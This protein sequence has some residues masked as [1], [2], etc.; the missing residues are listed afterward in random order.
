MN[1]LNCSTETKNPKF[2]SSSCSASYN[3]HTKPKRTRSERFCKH[4]GESVGPQLSRG[5]RGFC[6]SDCK[7][8]QL[9][10][11]LTLGELKG[12][13]NA[14]RGGR[15]PMI[16]NWSRKTYIRSGRPMEC[17]HC[18]YDYHVDICH[19]R[20]VSDFPLTATVE[21]V[22]DLSNLVALCRNHHW[23]F[24]HGHLKLSI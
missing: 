21:E 15:Y 19:I 24:D 14:N 16:R 4:C 8:G 17:F 18:G 23:E 20:D 11:T 22:N 7:P 13:G 12:S 1:C 10:H 5:A 2:C 9:S 3:N 6:C